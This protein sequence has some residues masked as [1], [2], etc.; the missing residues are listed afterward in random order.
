MLQ[1]SKIEWTN[2][3]INPVRGLC[4]VDCKDNQGKSYC[5]ARKMYKRFHWDETIRYEP[6]VFQEVE[7][8]ASK[9]KFQ[10]TNLKFFVGSTMELFGK[11]VKDE[12]MKE[13][14]W[15]CGS[16]PQFTFIFLSKEP[17]YLKK[18]D[19][20]NNAWVGISTT[21]N[22]SRSGLEDN[23]KEVKA[24]VKFVSIE[25]LLDYTPMD[26]RW[27]SWVIVGRC[28][29]ISEKTKPHINWIADICERA[30]A[31]RK[32]IFL[33]NNL[34]SMLREKTDLGTELLNFNLFYGDD[35]KLRQEFPK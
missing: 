35:F 10:P 24:K 25:P 28:T 33:K 17:H 6:E 20:P 32:P 22:D 11:W 7:D 15:F 19:F 26:F 21:G 29:P 14:L 18:W 27:V 13:I 34:S 2:F 5:Y 16:Y 30:D 23:L 4:P 12:W 9:I 1:K 3:S 31:E 8:L